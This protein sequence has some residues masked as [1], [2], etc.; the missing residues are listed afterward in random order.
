VGRTGTGKTLTT[1]HAL[2]HPQQTL[3]NISPVFM[4]FSARTSANQVG[5]TIFLVVTV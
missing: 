2:T 3:V 4:V 5:G 1:T